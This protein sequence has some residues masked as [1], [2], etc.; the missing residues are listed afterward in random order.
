[1]SLTAHG[2]ATP[3]SSGPDRENAP[4]WSTT[5]SS[6]P[7]TGSASRSCARSRSRR[8]AIEPT[9]P[10]SWPSVALRSSICR[11]RR[12]VDRPRAADAFLMAPELPTCFASKGKARGFSTG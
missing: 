1:M 8:A 10:R 2:S 5:P 12:R 9:S 6:V 11:P 7:A 3:H 4:L